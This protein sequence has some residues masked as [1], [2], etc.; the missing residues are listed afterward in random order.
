MPNWC[1]N[2]ATVTFKSRKAADE[3]V[4]ACK[5]DRILPVPGTLLDFTEPS[6]LFQHYLPM[7]ENIG[8]GW[9]YW[10]I[11]N[12]GTKWPPDIAGVHKL[13]DCIVNI[14][15]ST[16]WGPPLEWFRTCGMQYDWQ[17]QLEYIETGMG[18][19]GTAEGDKYGSNTDNFRDSEEEFA[20]IAE[21][22]G[23][24]LEDSP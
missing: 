21:H 2:D 1:S 23:I 18:F 10:C 4:G 22:F 17:W 5:S 19:A 12:W 15:F 13:S 24:E 20:E 16:A 11:D 3:F 14:S 8:D 6:N 7:P 9:Y